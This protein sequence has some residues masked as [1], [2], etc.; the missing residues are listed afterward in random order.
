MQELEV[1]DITNPT[2]K[3]FSWRYNGELFTIKAGETKGFAKAVGFHLAKHLSSQMICDEALVKATK[4]ELEDPRAQVHVKISQLNTY[5]THERR[6][7]LYK[8]LGD[9]ERVV[10]VIM[11]YPFKGFIGEMDEFKKFVESKK[12]K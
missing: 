4:K 9:E 1:I 8:I 6:I 11:N 3:D 7:A 10:Q 2:S 12:S 5:D